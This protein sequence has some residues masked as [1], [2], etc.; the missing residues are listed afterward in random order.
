M[1]LALRK[2]VP[3]LVPSFPARYRGCIVCPRGIDRF[4]DYTHLVDVPRAI[5]K[6]PHNLD[7]DDE[8]RIRVFRQKWI[9]IMQYSDAV[10]PQAPGM[11]E[12]DEK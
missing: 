9:V 6:Y 7:T 8:L 12:V 11:L 5:R 4:F 10:D 2:D 1:A 3:E